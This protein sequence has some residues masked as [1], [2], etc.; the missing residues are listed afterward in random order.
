MI[1]N[2]RHIGIIVKDLVLSARF[3]ENI[4]GLERYGHGIEYGNHIDNV[5]GLKNVNIE[6]IKFKTNNCLIELLKYHSHQT[7]SI[8]LPQIGSAHIAFTVK[9]IDV[10]C[11]KMNKNGYICNCDPQISADGRAKFMYCN[12]PD[13]IVL[14]LV[15]E[16]IIE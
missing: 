9:D 6:W 11:E 13:G 8:K 14:E 12:G 3:F 2:T 7:E 16:L 15:E 10:I 1:V 4:L 5:V